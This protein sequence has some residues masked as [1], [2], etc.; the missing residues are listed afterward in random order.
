MDIF[1]LI[2]EHD[3]RLDSL[4]ERHTD[5]SK[6]DTSMS[7][8]DFMKPDLTYSKFYFTGTRIKE[9]QFGINTLHLF[10]EIVKS[11]SDALKEYNLFTNAGKGTLK[12]FANDISI[13]Q[14]A[15]L[16]KSDSISWDLSTFVIDSNSN[17]GHNKDAIADVLKTDD[18]LLYKEQAH[19][20]FD[21]HLFSKNNIYREMFNPLQ[22][23]VSDQFRFFSMNGKRVTSERKFYFETWTLDR[24][25]HGTE[26]VFKETVL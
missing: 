20:G 14:P 4:R 2:Y 22:K 1:K 5:R 8:E 24:P 25:P 13:G 10:D 6:Q 21:F 11:L 17:V 7:I 9:Q 12:S 15:I 16:S 18:L 23:L 26:E 19:N 3:L